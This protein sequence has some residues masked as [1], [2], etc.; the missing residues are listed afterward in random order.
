M[1]LQPQ[2][3]EG[4]IPSGRPGAPR[5]GREFGRRVSRKIQRS[6]AERPVTPSRNGTRESP[7]YAATMRGLYRELRLPIGYLL[8]TTKVIVPAQRIQRMKRT[9]GVLAIVLVLT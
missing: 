9:F 2:P 3:L 7:Q 8:K 6:Q 1:W 4:P 5:F